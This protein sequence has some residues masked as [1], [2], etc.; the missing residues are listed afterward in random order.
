LSGVWAFTACETML[1]PPVPGGIVNC[2]TSPTVFVPMWF[3]WA[4]GP[5]L[6]PTGRTIGAGAP[7]ERQ[8]FASAVHVCT[9]VAE[10][11]DAPMAA[12]VFTHATQAFAPALQKLP[13]AQ[14]AAAERARHPLA[15][16]VHVCTSVPEH[17]VAPAL[18]QVFLQSG[19]PPPQPSAHAIAATKVKRRSRLIGAAPDPSASHTPRGSG[20]NIS[21]QRPAA[22][23]SC[24]AR[25]T[26]GASRGAID[27]IRGP[28]E[29]EHR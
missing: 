24:H 12:Q 3:P 21:M 11:S 26:I 20:R 10:H 28:L 15:S 25:A 18:A 13:V 8:P 19:P 6:V 4:A 14:G 17:C 27:S 7:K 2:T 9:W 16:A 22:I 29:A 23:R 1:K 5:A